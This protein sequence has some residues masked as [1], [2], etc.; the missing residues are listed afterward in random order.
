MFSEIYFV[1]IVLGG[2]FGIK[3]GFV[4]SYVYNE[5]CVNI[6]NKIFFIY[7]RVFKNNVNGNVN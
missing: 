1:L 5:V 4:I 6:S 3:I 7:Y 2:F